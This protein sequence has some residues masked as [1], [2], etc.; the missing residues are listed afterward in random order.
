MCKVT[1][2]FAEGA[3]DSDM[4]AGAKEMTVK[5]PWAGEG[6]MKLD[7]NTRE[8]VFYVARDGHELPNVDPS[9]VD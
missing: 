7:T 2:S 9:T 3:S 8:G 5:L 4:E 1:F 6:F